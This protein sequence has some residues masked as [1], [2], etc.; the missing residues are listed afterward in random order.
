MTFFL[1]VDAHRILNIPLAIGTMEDFVS[2][3][4]SRKW[5]LFS[6]VNVSLRMEPSTWRKIEGGGGAMDL[7]PLPSA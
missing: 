5:H 1:P 6:Q 4:F 7:A 2:W 3:H